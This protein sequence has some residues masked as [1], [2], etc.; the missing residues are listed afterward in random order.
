MSSNKIINWIESHRQQFGAP[1]SYWDYT[2]SFSVHTISER[3]FN[4]IVQGVSNDSSLAEQN[5]L[6]N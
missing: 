1:P 3:D 4:T 5:L 6:Q 2:D